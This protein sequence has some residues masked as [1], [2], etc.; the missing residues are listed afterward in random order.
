MAALPSRAQS[1]LTYHGNPDRS[2]NFVVPSLNWERARN[3]RLDR[4]FDPRFS[5]HVYAQ[6]LLWQPPSS[7]A[8]SLIV[9]TEDDT[10]HAI[11]ARSGGEVWE[12]TLGR[13]VALST[14][15]CGNIDPLGIT[16]TPVIETATEA[17]YLDAMVAEGSGPRHRIFA[18]SLKDGS[19]LPGWPVDVA[20]ALAAQG[21]H[22]N[23]R[24][25]NQRGALA[26][27]DGR[28]YVP[29]AGILAIA[30]IIAAGSSA[31]ECAIRGML[32]PGARGGGVAEFG[33]R[34]ESAATGIRFS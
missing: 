13:P 26:I 28:V 5:G 24:G 6:P 3:V 11:D 20:D 34:E 17:V 16:G 19:T 1:V 2:G 23:A 30:A 33:P 8:G 9:A 4:G 21:Q 7:A 14:Q 32:S 27:L 22:F 18:L 29:M 15:P 10:V 31:L 25:Q 12:R